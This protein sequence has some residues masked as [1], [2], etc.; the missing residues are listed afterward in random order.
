[1]KKSFVV[2]G[3]LAGILALGVFASCKAETEDGEEK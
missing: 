1:M 3:V 2:K